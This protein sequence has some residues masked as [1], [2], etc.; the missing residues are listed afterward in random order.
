[1]STSRVAR[2]SG[3]C[4]AKL[5]DD[6]SLHDRALAEVLEDAR[7]KPIEHEHLP[8]ASDARAARRGTQSCS[9]ACRKASGFS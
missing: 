9:S 3:T 7:E 4:E 6:A 8:E 1:M 5:E 2:R